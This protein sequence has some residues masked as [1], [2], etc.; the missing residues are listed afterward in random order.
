LEK[1]QSPKK[2]REEIDEA[3]ADPQGRR[4][5]IGEKGWTEISEFGRQHARR[6]QEE[7]TD[8]KRKSANGDAHSSIGAITELLAA[9]LSRTAA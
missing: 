5:T 6:W 1:D 4:Q 3:F 8:L 2:S 7:K 9:Y